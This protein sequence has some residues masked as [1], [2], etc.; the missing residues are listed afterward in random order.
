M[1][2]TLFLVIPCYNEEDIL[3]G[4][5]RELDKKVRDLINNKS[6]SE[7]SR[8]LFVN[9]GSKDRTWDII[10]QLHGENDLFSGINLAH[11]S[12]EQ[13]AYLAGMMTAKDKVD[14]VVTMDADLQDDIHAIDEMIAKYYEGNDIVYG[15]VRQERTNLFLSEQ[16]QERFIN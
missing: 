2:E 8:V 5:A 16:A 9:D 1:P 15:S 14:F 11:N 6:V 4:T 13:N 12:G 7:N 10:K 3:P